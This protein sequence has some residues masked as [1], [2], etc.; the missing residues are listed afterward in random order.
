MLTRS[1]AA[2]LSPNNGVD[3]GVLGV[4]AGA[5]AHMGED[6]VEHLENEINNNN[7]NARSEEE[8]YFTSDLYDVH[9]GLEVACYHNATGSCCTSGKA[10]VLPTTLGL[11]IDGI[12]EKLSLPLS[13]SHAKAIKSNSISQVIYDKSYHGVYSVPSA[14]LHIR[15][16]AWKAGFNKLLEK[17]AY[18]LGVDPNTLSAK[19]KMLLYMEKG[20]RID[21]HA[22]ALPDTDTETTVLGTLFVQLPSEFTGGKFSIF[23]GGGEDED[24]DEIEEITTNFDLGSSSGDS[25]FSCYFLAH[26]SDCEI[27]CSKV[28]SGTRLL[29]AYSLHKTARPMQTANSVISS[30]VSLRLWVKNDANNSLASTNPHLSFVFISQC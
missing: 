23:A 4:A 26:Y 1:T 3:V 12:G 25:A 6:N 13:E 21:R 29:L 30:M 28:Q 19:A 24:G 7:D 22:N 27:K 10:D 9:V 17:V 2:L 8:I 14:S 15:N 11:S 5:N 16:P 18:K 20:S